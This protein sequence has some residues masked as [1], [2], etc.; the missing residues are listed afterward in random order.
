MVALGE[1]DDGKS[2]LIGRLLHDAGGLTD[3]QMAD[4]RGWNGAL[5]LA[6]ATDG[7]RDERRH[8]ITIDTAYRHLTLAGRGVLLADAPGHRR[9]TANAL[10][11]MSTAHL[12]LVMVDATRG[13]TDQTRRHVLL[14]VFA[15]VRSMVVLVN[16]IDLVDDV[17]AVVERVSGEFADVVTDPRVVVRVVPVSALRGDNIVHRSARVE[18][19]N[20]LMEV[21][22]SA[23]VPVLARGAMF[24]AVHTSSEQHGSVGL[25]ILSGS[26]A[27][28][29]ELSV[30]GV[31]GR[32]RGVVV[33][34]SLEVT[35]TSLTAADAPRA[36]SALFTAARGGEA[37][38]RRGDWLV[39]PESRPTRRTSVQATACWL[40]PERTLPVDVVAL[41]HA[42]RFPV[43]LRAAS[44]LD[45]RTGTWSKARNMLCQNDIAQVE[46]ISDRPLCHITGTGESSD[47]IV[48]TDAETHDTVGCA[49][50]RTGRWLRNRKGRSA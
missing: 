8:G 45:V 15:G 43:R 7:L 39:G 29:A 41:Q 38:L 49:L 3:D 33:V 22:C 24:A 37:G 10:S 13:V 4:L 34:R 30:I 23:E 20:T 40:A 21:L 9:F 46:I 18:A 36:V 1:V 47:R 25:R 50:V 12:A 19:S 2:T 44:V 14:A 5:S 48:L 11:A 27:A 6:R 17:A 28:G 16:K 26:V 35:G 32:D 31:D 42:R